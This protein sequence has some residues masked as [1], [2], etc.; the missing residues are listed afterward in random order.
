MERRGAAHD[1]WANHDKSAHVITGS[2]YEQ[3]C[4]IMARHLCGWI[5][6]HSA[7]VEHFVADAD[8]IMREAHEHG[9]RFYLASSTENAGAG[10]VDL[11]IGSSR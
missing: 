6:G 10:F 8:L 3:M 4:R 5:S 11:Q 2:P 9:V 1:D 7:P